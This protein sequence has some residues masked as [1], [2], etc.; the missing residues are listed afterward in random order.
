MKDNKLTVRINKPV[1]EVF[2]F[3]ITPPNSTLWLPATVKEETDEWPAKI[4]TIYTLTDKAGAEFKVVVTALRDNQL[5]EWSMLDGSY[6]CRYTFRA[7]EDQVSELEYFE[8][9][10]SGELDEPFTQKT[11]NKLKQILEK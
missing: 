1:E 9:V 7:V 5:V 10:D 11:L 3:T 2:A 6:H 4:G 8:W